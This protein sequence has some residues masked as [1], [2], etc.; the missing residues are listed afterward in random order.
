M[1]YVGIPI[2]VADAVPE[3]KNVA[4]IITKNRG[5]Y[6]AVREFADLILKALTVSRN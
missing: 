5:G 4:R 6:G 1:S 3:I 2:A